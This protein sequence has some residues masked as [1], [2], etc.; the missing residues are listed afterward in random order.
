[1]RLKSGVN[2][3][4]YKAGILTLQDVMLVDY[5]DLSRMPGIS[6]NSVYRI[7]NFIEMFNSKE[8]SRFS[9]YS[10]LDMVSHYLTFRDMLLSVQCSFFNNGIITAKEFLQYVTKSD[11][12]TKRFSKII[13]FLEENISTLYLKNTE[14]CKFGTKLLEEITPVIKK[15]KERQAV[16]QFLADVF[17]YGF[18]EK[19][20]QKPLLYD[21][22]IITKF[23]ENK[24]L[25]VLAKRLIVEKCL[26]DGYIHN[27]TLVDKFGI[28]AINET[29]LLK[30]EFDSSEYKLVFDKERSSSQDK[31][32]FVEPYTVREW[33]SSC[34]GNG[35]H[36]LIERLEGK[37]LQD[38]GIRESYSRENIRLVC[39]KLLQKKPLLYE[40]RW[41]PLFH[42]YAWSKKDFVE[43]TGES[44]ETYSYLCIVA[45]QGK[46]LLYGILSDDEVPEDIKERYKSRFCKNVRLLNGKYTHI[47]SK[48]VLDRAVEI[49]AKDGIC[50]ADFL[51]KYKKFLEVNGLK[52][53]TVNERAILARLFR[54]MN[55]LFTYGDR[56]R[57]Y[58]IM[59]LEI[60]YLQK[61][62]GLD[63]YS[64]CIISSKLLF[65]KKPEL[66]KE[67]DIRD[68]YELHNLFRKRAKELTCHSIS[69]HRMPTILFGKMTRKEQVR[70]FLKSYDII[71][72]DK[73]AKLYCEKYGIEEDTFCA[74]YSKYIQAYRI[75]NGLF[76]YRSHADM[77]T[78][79]EIAKV[80]GVL[81]DVI[82]SLKDAL[83]LFAKKLPKHRV[84]CFDD[85][86][87]LKLGYRHI[88]NVL[89]R[90]EFSTVGEAMDVYFAKP[91]TKFD[92][93]LLGLSSIRPYLLKHMDE[94]NLF[95][96]S[97]TEI[98]N[99][100]WLLN[101]GFTPFLIQNFV[102]SVEKFAGNKVF[103]LYSLQQ[104]GFRH[105]ILENTKEYWL[106]SS[107]LRK[108]EQFHYHT[109]FMGILFDRNRLHPNLKTIIEDI[110]K[111]FGA[112][113]TN[114][115]VETIQLRFGVECPISKVELINRRLGV[116][117]NSD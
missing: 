25:F 117:S 17:V 93:S 53:K 16:F 46:K 14:F 87:F 79:K 90:K 26:Q 9:S 15:P 40:D 84:S 105:K 29:F 54:S 85:E 64:D 78:E 19:K 98:V 62:L 48:N 68:E 108:S 75:G 37:S 52:Q 63:E 112:V 1:M 4:L 73:L 89:F 8:I 88:K 70:N 50:I 2:T 107:F 10:W 13:R 71:T 69:F 21:E 81:T 7:R 45:K 114:Q 33:L 82:Y 39:N 47:S 113:S 23:Y 100:Q 103:S 38:I 94:C 55:V 104:E 34:S 61:E 28:P 91:V 66:M 72:L 99:R 3:T 80:K 58:P 35:K 36:W 43:L 20:L 65:N 57:Y 115:L 42:E 101:H 27:S 30:Q 111:E 56:F 110:Y 83:A 59:S 24:D 22:Y 31:V 49:F 76:R 6:Y 44:V 51:V 32:F 102:T 95:R 86:V 18:V 41:I 67:Y 96:R 12:M 60:L 74:G 97:E 92:K 106:L 5:K 109:S 11:A 116:S 77:L